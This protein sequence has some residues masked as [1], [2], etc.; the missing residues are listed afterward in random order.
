MSVPIRRLVTALA[1]LALTGAFAACE[2]DTGEPADQ[3]GTTMGEQPDQEELAADQPDQE[4]AETDP[5]AADDTEQDQQQE[6]DEQLSMDEVRQ[7]VADRLDIDQETVTIDDEMTQ[8]IEQAQS[9]DAKINWATVATVDHY[10]NEMNQADLD[11]EERAAID[12]I[13]PRLE[14]AQN[15][16]EELGDASQEEREA[17][18]E[19]TQEHTD[20]IAEEFSALTDRVEQ[21]QQQPAGGGPTDEHPADDKQQNKDGQQDEQG[22]ETNE[23]MAP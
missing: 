2:P 13:N 21:M 23:P 6:Q 18:S 14:Q 1:L 3:E 19:T 5:M 20:A 16:L 8:K 15:S 7:E 12:A 11:D 4:G 22:Q 9:E 10:V 17:L